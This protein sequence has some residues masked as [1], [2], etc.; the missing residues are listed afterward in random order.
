MFKLTHLIAADFFT[1]I[2]E[3]LIIPR[4]PTPGCNSFVTDFDAC[5][6][7]QCGRVP[8]GLGLPTEVSAQVGVGCGAHFC[9]WCMEIC[10]DR[11]VCHEHVRNCAFNPN[12]GAMIDDQMSVVCRYFFVIMSYR[13]SLSAATSSASLE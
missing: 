7:L 8:P 9:A 1:H 13:F 2:A 10:P 3:N 5:A 6:G 4:C 11:H 12:K